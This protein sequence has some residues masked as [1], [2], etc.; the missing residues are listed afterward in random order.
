MPRPVWLR[1]AGTLVVAALAGAACVHPAL[2]AHG[3]VQWKTIWFSS[4]SGPS[5]GS[6][7]GRYWT[8][9]TGQGIFG[10]GET[11]AMLARKSRRYFGALS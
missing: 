11:E 4:F 8:Y 10:N 2:V 9:Q 5:G 3:A 6:V 1:A 7:N